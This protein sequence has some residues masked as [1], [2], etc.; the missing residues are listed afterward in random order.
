MAAKNQKTEPAS[1]T[2]IFQAAR[3][4]WR[5]EGLAG[6]GHRIVRK[7]KGRRS[8]SKEV[9]L[10]GRWVARYATLSSS[11]RK[12][13]RK[14]IERLNYQ[15]VISVVMPVYNINETWLRRAIKS[16]QQQ[17]Y[18]H[19]QLS[20]ADDCSTAPH[21]RRVL[22]E[23]AAGD[24]RI[25]VVF[26]DSNGHISVASNSALAFA[27]GEFVALLDHDDELTEHAL[28]MVAE[29]LNAHPEA[30][31]I[32]TD[33]DKINING[34]LA[35]PHF[36]PDWNPDLFLSMNFISHLGVYRRSILERIGGFRTG[37]EGSQDYDLALRVVEQIPE[38][39]IRHIP[40]VLYHWRES[41]GSV[42]FNIEAKSYAHDNARRALDSH[43]QRVGSNAKIEPGYFI[44]HRAT[45]PLTQPL[46]RVTLIAIAAGDLSSFADSI[47]S[48]VQET[49]YPQFELILACRTEDGAALAG[50]ERLS[51]EARIRILVSGRIAETSALFNHAINTAEGN[52]I[53]VLGS[54][55]A[56][57]SPGWLT[58]MASQALR[59]EIGIVGAKIYDANG[60]VHHAGVIL[61]AHGVA[62]LAHQGLRKDDEGYVFRAQVMQNFSAV[63]GGCLVC[64]R[65]V[66]EEAGGFGEMDLPELLRDVDLCLRVR[67]KG[68]RVLWTP[69][70]ELGRTASE[71]SSA[72]STGAP[73][74][75][76]KARWANALQS[77]SFYNRNLSVES[78][79]FCL[80][81]PP[82]TGKC[83]QGDES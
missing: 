63:S 24:A 13:I 31:L 10:Y 54:D 40:H 25:Q 6:V 2:G 45:Y 60:L 48:F 17:L 20:I 38:H 7:I 78:A 15:P 5:A 83:W 51:Q 58:E 33:E 28:Y 62:G 27:S 4:V 61:G 32:Y 16:V 39:H 69:Y 41:P 34:Q 37:Y 56:P 55:I 59:P 23:F 75:Y 8:E 29:E 47:V 73:V 70:A 30:D 49:D 44:F 76:L 77:D 64:R 36:K 65:E 3:Q 43:F 81:F 14:R 46:P 12:A 68:Y 18:P 35:D 53:G 71:F 42:G 26:R 74:R 52:I 9:R 50:N 80:A 22:E 67:E 72:S 1:E 79:N 19:W 66:F 11:D 21:V 82:R 57:L